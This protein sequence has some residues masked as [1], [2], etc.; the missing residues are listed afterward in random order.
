MPLTKRADSQGSAPHRATMDDIAQACG[1]S[2]MTVSRVLANRP[3]VGTETRHRVEAAAKKLNYELNSMAR[4]FNL[5]RSGFIGIAIP[6]EGLI[7]SYYFGEIF[8]GFSHALR[9]SAHHFAL[10]DTAA[11]LFNDGS[12]LA[13]LYRQRKVDGLLIVSPHTDDEFLQTLKNLRVPLVVVGESVLDPSVCSITCDDAAGVRAVCQHL[14]ELGHRKIAFIGGPEGLISSERRKR[15]FELFCQGNGLD[16]PAAYLQPGDY[17]MRAGRQAA[18]TLLDSGDRPTAIVAANDLM[19]FGAMETARA[20]DLRLPGDF[21]VAGFDDLPTAVDRFPALT[22]V[23]QPVSAMAEQGAHILLRALDEQK[24]PEGL[25]TM[26]VSLTV[27]G[28]TGPCR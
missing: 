13:R 24:I 14:F 7:G 1:L 21:S 26:D 8:R 9:G 18:L 11:D 20:L 28:S 4:N 15:T 23:S 3:G 10:F 27:R 5:N 25:I 16:L 17:T 2:K 19:A 12:K 22:T 6:T